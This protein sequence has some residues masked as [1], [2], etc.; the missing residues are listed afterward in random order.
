VVGPEDILEL[1]GPLASSPTHRRP[2]GGRPCHNSTVSPQV[3]VLRGPRDQS[4][5]E[6][7]IQAGPQASVSLAPSLPRRL[8]LPYSFTLPPLNGPPKA[9]LEHLSFFVTPG[10][11]SG[12]EHGFHL[13]QKPKVHREKKKVSQ[14]RV[15]LATL[16]L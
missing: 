3:T 9:H 16:G 2:K 5:G 8:V 1:A 12:P 6:R 7:K 10:C 13:S 4:E 14:A 15:E 11:S